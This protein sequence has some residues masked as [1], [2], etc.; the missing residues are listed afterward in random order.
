MCRILGEKCI[1]KPRSSKDQTFLNLG[2][3]L[4]TKGFPPKAMFKF[5]TNISRIILLVCNTGVAIT[6]ACSRAS[7]AEN[8]IRHVE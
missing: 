3:P 7:A 5:A 1:F 4:K 2:S 6:R 8:A